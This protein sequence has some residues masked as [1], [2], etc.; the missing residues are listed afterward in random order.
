MRRSFWN[1]V[2]AIARHSET[3]EAMVV[4]RALYGAGE[5]WVRPASMWNE[6]V[7]RGGKTYRRFYRLDRIER[8]ENYERLFEEAA[9]CPDADKLRLLEEYYT[10]GQ[11][12]KDYTQLC[13]SGLQNA[14]NK[15]G[16]ESTELGFYCVKGIPI[17]SQL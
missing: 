12:R 11:W 10:S 15:T 16:Q 13:F 6:T 1:E 2:T 9:A 17:V 3:E 14:K 4:Y 5:V 8:V 7:E